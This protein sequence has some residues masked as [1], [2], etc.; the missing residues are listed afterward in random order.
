[1]AVIFAVIEGT[2]LRRGAIAAS[3]CRHALPGVELLGLSWNE[4]FSQ[5]TTIPTKSCQTVDEYYGAL[6]ALLSRPKQTLFIPCTQLGTTI[7]NTYGA[8]HLVLAEP[9]LKQVDDFDKLRLR[10]QQH[11]LSALFPPCS[12]A[13]SIDIPFPVLAKPRIGHSSIGQRVVKNL[14]DINQLGALNQYFVEAVL[15]M[16][17]DEYSLTVVRSPTTTAW[18]CTRRI[19]QE[20]GRTTRSS[21]ALTPNAVAAANLIAQ[22]LCVEKIYNVQFALNG[23]WPLIYDLNPRFGHSELYRTCFGFNF[24]SA[25]IGSSTTVHTPATELEEDEAFALLSLQPNK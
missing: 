12:P 6:R 2:H 19:S 15:P 9:G 10:T 20:D 18:Q 4:P 3:C 24:I 7:C 25:F 23:K 22:K 13:E 1:M 5:G 11:G 16:P 8:E 17:L 21:K 14:A